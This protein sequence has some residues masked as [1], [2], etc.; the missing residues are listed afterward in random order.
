MREALTLSAPVLL[1]LHRNQLYIKANVFE[2]HFTNVESV[3]LLR[4]DRDL[5]I[6]PLATSRAGGFYIKQVN[7][8]GDRAI[9]AADFFRLN[10]I[11]ENNVHELA[12]WPDP[13]MAGFVIAEFFQS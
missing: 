9:H 13:L 8:R 1:R 6:L 5:L 10:G 2:T 7:A 3:A 4:K 11:D 12:A